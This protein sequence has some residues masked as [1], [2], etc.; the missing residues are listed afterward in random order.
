[1]NNQKDAPVEN[2]VNLEQ[3]DLPQL[4]QLKGQ[5]DQ[6]M[7]LYRSSLVKLKVAKQKFSSCIDG[8]KVLSDKLNAASAEQ[9]AES[10]IPLTGSLFVKGIVKKSALDNLMVDIGTGYFVEKNGQDA[11][12]YYQSKVGY[13]T[14]QINN[15]EALIAEKKSNLDSVNNVFLQKLA[16]SKA[17]ATTNK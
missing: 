13:L 4:Q 16:A 9:E 15:L 7:Q 3:L 1:M 2:E 5:F 6:E 10:L 14:E 12:K 8:I 17:T 11:T